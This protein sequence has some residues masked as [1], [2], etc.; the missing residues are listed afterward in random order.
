M[1]SPLLRSLKAIG[2]EAAIVTMILG[3]STPDPRIGAPVE[4]SGGDARRLLDLISIGKT[5]S[6]QRIAAEETPPAFLQVEPAGSFGNEDVVKARMLSQP[7]PGLGTVMT[8]EIVGN[9]VDLP[10]GLSTSMS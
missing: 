2:K 3:R 6:R 4:L 10:V 9:H 8:A 1:K 5:L 7:G